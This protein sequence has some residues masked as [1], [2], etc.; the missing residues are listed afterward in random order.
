MEMRNFLQ[1]LNIHPINSDYKI[2]VFR[3]N[4][5]IFVKGSKILK[6]ICCTNYQNCP[7][8]SHNLA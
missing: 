1:Y 6:N 8:L 2:I 5:Q 7:F 3:N 4:V